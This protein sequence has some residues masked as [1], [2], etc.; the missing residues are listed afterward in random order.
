MLTFYNE[1]HHQHSG[2]FEI[3]RG[4]MVPCFETPARADAVLA[5]LERRGLGRIVTPNGVP[6]MSLERVHTPRRK[7]R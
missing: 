4:E 1:L 3:F 5:E 6:L 7:C 2:R